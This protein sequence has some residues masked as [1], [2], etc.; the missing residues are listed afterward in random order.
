MRAVRL[1]APGQELRTEE[2]PIP[3]PTGTEIRIRVA[4]CGVCHTDLHIVDGTQT[5]VALPVTLGHE[6]AGWVDAVGPD[7]GGAHALDSPVLV[8]GGWGCGDCRDCR[9]GAEQRCVRSVAPG[10]QAD[11]GYADAMLVPH[12]R[13]LV[14]L[15]SLDP[16]RAAPLADAGVTPYRAVRRAERW[17]TPGARVLL[18]GCGALGQFALQYLRLVPDAGPRL[19][20]AVREQSPLR[21]GRAKELGADI[22]L[23]D[24]D[25]AESIEALGGPADVV[26]DFVGT[27]ATLASAAATVAPDGLVVLIGEAGGSLPF[28]FDTVPV[29][30]WLTTVAWG[31]HDDLRQV[32]RLAESGALRWDVDPVPLGEASAAHV[33]L[34]AGGVT[35]RLVLVP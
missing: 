28:G 25:A 27:D 29:E 3:E 13:H 11:G 17:L 23:L 16:V 26:L 12:P 31:A 33:R 14:P 10:F 9:A 5:R 19:Q 7:A 18:I 20:I 4:G 24:G 34:R 2:V 30:S 21:L 15:G 32:V 6:V 22:T 8:H 1:Q 35:G